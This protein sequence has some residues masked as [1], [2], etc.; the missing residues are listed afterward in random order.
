MDEVIC[1]NN[2]ASLN[3]EEESSLNEKES[4]ESMEEEDDNE[5]S[6]D[7]EGRAP[8]CRKLNKLLEEIESPGNFCCGNVIENVANPGLEVDSKS[9]V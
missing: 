1:N 7:E 8:Y 3:E 9:T 6:Q 2:N 5:F 4:N